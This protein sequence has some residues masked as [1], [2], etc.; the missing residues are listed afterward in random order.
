MI[1]GWPWAR[2]Q[3]SYWLA[4]IFIQGT[5]YVGKA[6]RTM[7]A[8]VHN[9]SAAHPHTQASRERRVTSRVV[10]V[11]TDVA[12]KTTA[13]RAVAV[14]QAAA[15]TPVQGGFASPHRWSLPAATA[16]SAANAN[17]KR[18]TFSGARQLGGAAI[19]SA[20]GS[21]R[22]DQR[23][24]HSPSPR[25]QT[26]QADRERLQV[27][28]PVGIAGGDG[29]LRAKDSRSADETSQRVQLLPGAL[30]RSET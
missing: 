30:P 24:I 5:L 1:A 23:A 29:G 17:G 9:K 2:A 14:S 19:S 8:E 26:P 13:S 11:H 20:R 3:S 12:D 22:L 7:N 15:A 10:T 25:Q 21:L 4:A 6:V 27:G 28:A 16:Q 18:F